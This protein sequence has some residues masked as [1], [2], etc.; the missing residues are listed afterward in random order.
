MIPTIGVMI[1]GYII[2][3]CLEIGCRSK[4]SFSS[5]LARTIVVI[6]AILGILVTGFFTLDLLF[7]G[8]ATSLHGETSPIEDRSTEP[9]PDPHAHRSAGGSCWCDSGYKEDPTT[10]RCVNE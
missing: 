8:G 10:V 9:C 3:R 1:G 7:T 6:A 4:A 5:D 2:F